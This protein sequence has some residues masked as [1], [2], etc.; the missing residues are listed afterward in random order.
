MCSQKL[1]VLF[2]SLGLLNAA[3]CIWVIPPGIAPP[4]RDPQTEQDRGCCLPNSPIL[5]FFVLVVG[6]SKL[7]L[8]SFHGSHVTCSYRQVDVPTT[9]DHR[10]LAAVLAPVT[11]FAATA[12]EA[13]DP[14]TT[15][16]SDSGTF[17]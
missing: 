13:A 4:T 12:Q 1:L 6:G 8:D 14:I 16:A 10:H 2:I 11:P 5:I 9:E 17:L 3:T 7:L 15:N